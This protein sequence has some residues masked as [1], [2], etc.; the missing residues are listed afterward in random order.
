MLE[1]KEGGEHIHI[2][3]DMKLNNVHRQV[4]CETVSLALNSI[5]VLRFLPLNRDLERGG[6]GHG[7]SEE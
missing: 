7:Y 2:E 3:V 6:L 4:G 5:R 1:T